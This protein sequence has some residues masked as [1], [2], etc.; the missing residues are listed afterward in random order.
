MQPFAE[1]Q[2]ENRMLAA[3]D[4]ILVATD[5][6]DG[7]YLLPHAIAQ[8]AASQA[9]V[10]LVHGILPADLMFVETGALSLTNQKAIDDGVRLELLR[11]A[12]K[13]EEHGIPCEIVAEHGFAADVVL[14]QIGA[15]RANRLIMGTH[16]RGKLAHMALG[17]V[18]SELLSR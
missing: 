8:A 13:I 3:P 10:T 14:K 4:R 9:R 18:A 17:S 15:T 11:L 16:G 2:F 5:L 7:E 12:A 6:T 1:N